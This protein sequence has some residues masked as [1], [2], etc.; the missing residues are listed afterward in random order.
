MIILYIL[1]I[2]IA[3]WGIIVRHRVD[4]S[5]DFDYLSKNTTDSIKGIFILTVFLRHGNQ[6]VADSGYDYSFYGDLLFSDTDLF[7]GQSIVVLFLF[8]SGYG[9]MM[10]ILSKGSTYINKMPRHRILN[11]LVNFD[12]AVLFFVILSFIIGHFYPLRTYILSFVVWEDIGN[13]NWYI[14]DILVCYISTWFSFSLTKGKKALLLNFFVVICIWAVLQASGKPQWWYNTIMA[15]PVGLLYGLYREKITSY[16]QKLFLLLM[17]LAIIIYIV[18]YYSPYELKGIIQN[19]RFLAF[20][21]IVILLSIRIR[22]H[23]KVLIWLGSNLFI[24]YIYQRIP[25][26]LLNEYTKMNPVLFILSSFILT[27]VLVYPL[28]KIQF[29]L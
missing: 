8:Y 9:V 26:I 3:L 11:T 5:H 19:V 1:I 4:G 7:L 14:F 10:S 29:K 22:L 28:Q 21:E 18:L 20:V 25:M 24:L 17:P 15:Y 2:V 27:C 16:N 12:V 6:Y 13:S 23:N